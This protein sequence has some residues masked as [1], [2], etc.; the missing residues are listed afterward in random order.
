MIKIIIIT[1]DQEFQ[2]Q[3]NEIRAIYKQRI[4]LIGTVQEDCRNEN[5]RDRAI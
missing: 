5:N 4:Q 2:A 1:L 3:L